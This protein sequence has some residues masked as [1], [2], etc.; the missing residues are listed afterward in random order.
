MITSIAFTVYPVTDMAR[1]RN[2]YEKVL[3]LSTS[4]TFGNEW[5]EYDVGGS[6]LSRGRRG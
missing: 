5:A 3:G 1:S 2:F 4:E 6:T